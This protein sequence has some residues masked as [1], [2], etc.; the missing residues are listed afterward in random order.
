MLKK[1]I[2]VLL[3]LFTAVAFAAVDVNK[4]TQADLEAVK[5][6]G[7]SAASKI[8]TERKKGSFKDWNDVMERVGGIK[9]ARAVK[10]SDA[11]LTVNGEG[12]KGGAAK[13]ADKPA[14]AKK[15]A[16]ADKAAKP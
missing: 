14:K 13:K 12:F 3:A 5:G 7:P 4:A 9:E 11:G 16:G 15:G 10:L 6:I 1:L 8:L 2:A